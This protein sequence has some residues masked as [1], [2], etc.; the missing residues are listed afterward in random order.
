MNRLCTMRWL[1][2]FA[3]DAVVSSILLIVL[4]AS[5]AWWSWG[6]I[7]FACAASAIATVV[8]IASEFIAAAAQ[9]R[10]LTFSAPTLAGVVIGGITIAMF[11]IGM[12]SPQTS[13]FGDALFWAGLI[14]LPVALVSILEIVLFAIL[15]DD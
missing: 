14:A 7:G 6:L 1:C 11:V 13:A 4:F 10:R 9:R 12:L 2:F 15:G 8:V 5:D 3:I